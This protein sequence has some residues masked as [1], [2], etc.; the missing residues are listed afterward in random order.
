MYTSEFIENF[1]DDRS[2]KGYLFEVDIEYPKHLHKSHEDLPFSAEK[3]K[4][5]H[6]PFKHEISDDI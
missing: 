2:S 6:K 1:D 5:L 3:R 4:K